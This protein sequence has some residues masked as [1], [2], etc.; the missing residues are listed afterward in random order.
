[1][2]RRHTEHDL[3]MSY[4]DIMIQNKDGSWGEDEK[5]DISTLAIIQPLRRVRE[6]LPTGLR[7]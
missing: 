1:M 2:T 3:A 7:P 6:L 5:R 4:G